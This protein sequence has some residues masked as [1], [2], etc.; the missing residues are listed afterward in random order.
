MWLA[1]HPTRKLSH[2]LCASKSILINFCFTSYKLFQWPLFFFFLFFNS[3]L[4]TILPGLHEDSLAERLFGSDLIKCACVCVCTPVCACSG[5]IQP[6]GATM[7]TLWAKPIAIQNHTTKTPLHGSSS[8]RCISFCLW[9][10]V[11]YLNFI[12]GMKNS[13]CNCFDS[14]MGSAQ[15]N[16]P[17]Q[18]KL[19]GTLSHS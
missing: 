8:T 13:T 2:K 1:P 14:I 12:A 11:Q 9:L 10:C 15:A 5:K 16:G 6:Q 18:D 7:P 17:N 19:Q 3:R 4:P